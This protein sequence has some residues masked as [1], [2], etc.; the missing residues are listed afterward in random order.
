MVDAGAF[1]RLDW[2]TDL[3]LAG[4]SLVT[5]MPLFLFISGA[6]RLP[7]STMGFLQYIAPSCTFLLAVFIYDEP[8]DGA[9]L[10]AFVLIWSALVIFSYDSLHHYHLGDTRTDHPDS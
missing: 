9:L 10:T 3:L 7:L 8:L 6:R 1:L 5:A 2:R 4:C